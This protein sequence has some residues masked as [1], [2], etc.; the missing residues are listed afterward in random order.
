MQVIDAVR[1]NED[2]V[3]CLLVGKEP[4]LGLDHM[5]EGSSELEQNHGYKSGCLA[6]RMGKCIS[7]LSVGSPGGEEMGG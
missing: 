4:G 2:I 6:S 5:A 1:G 3:S 7:R